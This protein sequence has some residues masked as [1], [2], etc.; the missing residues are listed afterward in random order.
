[1]RQDT[2]T[3][4]EMPP[5]YEE[6]GFSRGTAPTD[7]RHVQGSMPWWNPRYWRKRVWGGVAAVIVIIIVVVVAVV[8]TQNK[9]N[10]YPN[11]AAVGYSLSETCKSPVDLDGRTILTEL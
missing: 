6:V 4:P 11:Y 8:V 3:K 5:T 7:V 10:A 2:F 9:N 1:M